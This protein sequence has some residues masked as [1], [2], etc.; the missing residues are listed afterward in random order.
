MLELDSPTA[1][2]ARLPAEAASP[3][4]R[5]RIYEDPEHRIGHRTDQGELDRVGVGSSQF[6]YL[7]AE[8]LKLLTVA[9]FEHKTKTTAE[10]SQ[11]GRLRALGALKDGWW[12]DTQHTET[13]CALAIWRAQI[14]ET[15]S[16]DTREELHFQAQLTDY[17]L[18]LTGESGGV[19]ENWKPDAPPDEWTNT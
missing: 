7:S 13:F 14:D 10:R 11:N 1:L 18:M 17:H 12:N 6:S 3:A 2:L 8:T 16:A 9:A 5:A 4:I 19:G 15:A